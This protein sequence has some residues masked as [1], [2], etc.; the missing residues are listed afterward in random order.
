MKRDFIDKIK[1]KYKTEN[2]SV[3]I[4]V[5][6]RIIN[7]ILII[8]IFIFYFYMIHSSSNEVI[9]K[10]QQLIEVKK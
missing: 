5:A 4:I 9:I 8:S 10:G 6:Y 1:R 7:I 3:A 2:L